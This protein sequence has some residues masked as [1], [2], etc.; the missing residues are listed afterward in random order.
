M[1][2]IKIVVCVL[3]GLLLLVWINRK[4]SSP[5]VVGEKVSESALPLKYAHGFSVSKLPDDQGY[6]LNMNGTDASQPNVV[7]L[8]RKGAEN[9]LSI[10]QETRC[11]TIPVDRVACNSTTH[12]EFLRLLGVTSKLCGM[13]NAEYVY[14]DTIYQKVKQGE[15]VQLGNS[16]Q[17]DKERLLLANPD[18]LYLSDEREK[19]ASANCNIMVCEEWKESTALA[20]AEWIKFFA[21]FFDQ[22]A[23][24]DS[25]F[26]ETERHYNE[27]KEL[28]RT[29]SV[30]PTLFAA[31]CYGDTWYLT[32]GLGYM[33]ALYQDA[34][35]SF[36]LADTMVGTVTCGMEWVLSSCQ[37]ADYW[38][39]CQTEKRDE[40]DERLALLSS[41]KSENIF[42][43]NKRSVKRPTAYIS[44][45][46]ESAVAHPDW[47]LA[48]VAATLHPHLFP[49]YETKYVG[50]VK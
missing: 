47:L 30:R 26:N 38:L 2:K 31:G 9:T 23:L 8:L 10:S 32:G 49:G 27:I 6:L 16:M 40:L 41:Y 7:L 50:R 17:V 25:L 39:N 44:D 45:F 37:N 33:S 29:D 35:A 19:P 13:C 34:N 28:A 21:L 15:I 11:V 24:A 1:N 14:S 42:H 20:R 43:F 3:L 18:V 48:D 5:Q 36:L 46:Y 4:S 12:L 22:Y